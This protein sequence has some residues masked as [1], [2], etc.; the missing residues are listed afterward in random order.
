MKLRAERRIITFLLIIL[1]VH[2]QVFLC[3]EDN[4]GQGKRRDKVRKLSKN[5]EKLNKFKQ[6]KAENST[7]TPDSD[8]EDDDI[9]D[10]MTQYLTT[11]TTTRMLK[12][13]KRY[14]RVRSTS[15]SSTTRLTTPI[16]EAPE[17]EPEANNEEKL[18]EYLHSRR[19]NKNSRPK[20]IWTDPVTVKIGMA[21][22]HLGRFLTSPWPSPDHLD[23]LYS[24]SGCSEVCHW[25]RCLDE[26]YLAG[27]LPHLGS[28][29]LRG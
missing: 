8:Y 20:K 9:N 24:R 21:L 27:W 13:S 3:Q 16:T 4:S 23:G 14:D 7:D 19:L 15:I 6:I 17:P 1:I 12:T 10:T 5:K 2:I 11:T 18:M 29:R 22:I 25:N 28:Q 26:V